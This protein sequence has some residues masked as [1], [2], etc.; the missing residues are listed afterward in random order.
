MDTKRRGGPRLGRQDEKTLTIPVTGMTCASCV[1]RVE[2]AL[3]KVPGVLGASVNL[4]N[5]KATVRYLAGE[6]EPRDLEKAVEGAGYGVVWED[7][8]EASDGDAH[9]KEYRRL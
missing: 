8:A 4:A 1:G 6:V 2:R 9:E 3:K 5:E 7:E